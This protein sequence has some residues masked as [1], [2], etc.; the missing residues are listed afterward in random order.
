MTSS[1][2]LSKTTTAES[3]FSQIA[4]GGAQDL[5]C[6]IEAK[7]W[8]FGIQIQCHPHSLVLASLDC[9]A[10]MGFVRND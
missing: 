9:L 8:F 4:A 3:G 10:A 6:R 5:E 2:P 7:H 1:P